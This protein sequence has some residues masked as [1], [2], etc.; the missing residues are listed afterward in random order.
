M[1]IDFVHMRERTHRDEVAA[2]SLKQAFF[3]DDRAVDIAPLSR[4]LRRRAL[5]GANRPA[6]QRCHLFVQ[7]VAFGRSRPPRS[8]RLRALEREGASNRGA[9][10]TFCGRRPDVAA[11]L[12]SDH[13]EWR[14]ALTDRLGPRFAIE[15]IAGLARDL[16]DVRTL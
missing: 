12:D 15:A 5:V 1:A 7:A 11:W 2:A 13:I 3:D 10:L 4:F 6:T 9:R 16:C 8:P 14:A